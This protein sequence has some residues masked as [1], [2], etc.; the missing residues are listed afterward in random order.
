MQALFICHTVVVVVVVRQVGSSIWECS[1]IISLVYFLCKDEGRWERTGVRYVCPLPKAERQREQDVDVEGRLCMKHRTGESWC[2][3]R[4]E[5]YP[6]HSI[7]VSP[8]RR[9][10]LRR[11]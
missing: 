11:S 5:A 3:T 10:E 1:S 2:F 8:S 6:Q 4:E 9:C 7:L